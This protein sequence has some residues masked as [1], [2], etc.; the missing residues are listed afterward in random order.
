M[1]FLL[2]LLFLA[3][4]LAGIFYRRKEKK[5]WVA[6]ERYDDS[7]KWID[8]RPGERGTFGS[9]DEE[10]EQERLYVSRQGRINELTRLIRDYAFENIPD[11]YT[12][13]DEEIKAFSGQARN[14]A[15]QLIAT[16][17]QAQ[18]GKMPPGTAAQPVEGTA[19]LKKLILDFT[20][21][22]F[23]KMLDQDLEIIKA[24]DAYIDGLSA[25]V[26]SRN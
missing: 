13:S 15:H 22:N 3:L 14:M 7:G 6:D 21:R 2:S 23:P 10:M 12:K 18:T 19:A 20:Y 1:N 16:V 9:R 5:E 11:L 24:F 25:E 26:I 8:K 4:L 17:E